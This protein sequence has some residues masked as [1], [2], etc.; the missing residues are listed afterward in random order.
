MDGVPLVFVE[1][2]VQNS[3]I[4]TS[5]ELKQLSSAWG[6]VGEVQTKNNGEL[7]LSFAPD[8]GD[9]RLHYRMEDFDHIESRTLSREVVREMSKSI[10][11]IRFL[12]SYSVDEEWHSVR[13]DDVNLLQLLTILDAPVKELDIDMATDYLGPSLYIKLRSKYLNLFKSF[14]YLRLTRFKDTRL[15][16]DTILAPR[17]RSVYIEPGFKDYGPISFWV[18]FF[19]SE[20]C[21]RLEIDDIDVAAALIEH[22]K[23][24]DPRTLKYSKVF[25]AESCPSEALKDIKMREINLEAKAP[26]LE[27][28]KK[29][30]GSRNYIKSFH[31]IDHPV[32]PSSKIYV[33]VYR[34]IPHDDL[35]LLFD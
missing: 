8:S 9:W 21:M 35:A 20:K 5:E 2:V 32:D 4:D 29:K 26:L 18:D 10:T 12:P 16:E 28:V 15:M 14:T 13:P 1:S 25:Y 23:K 34:D 17:V 6:R 19:F 3:D 7:Y 27:K 33:L 22:W 24:I 31:C 11:T 30:V